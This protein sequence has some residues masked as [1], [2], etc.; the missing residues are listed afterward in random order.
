VK[1]PWI[2][3]ASLI[4]VLGLLAGVVF[5]LDDRTVLV[6][7]PEAVVESF[8]RKLEMGRYELATDH[9]SEAAKQQI[10]A[11]T[12]QRLTEALKQKTGPIQDVSGEP[13]T[14]NHDQAQASATL[15]LPDQRTAHLR[16]SLKREHGLWRIHGLGDLAAGA[17]S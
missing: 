10:D 13:G 9:L 6:P 12:L 8:V 5:G 16:F 14:M 3:L 17:A 4:A 7:P 11:A 2:L 15:E 1:A